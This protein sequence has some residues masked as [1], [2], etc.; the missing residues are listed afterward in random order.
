ML[1][2]EVVPNTIGF[3]RS[4]SLPAG[5]TRV[6][7]VHGGSYARDIQV[8]LHYAKTPWTYGTFATYANLRL[9]CRKASTSTTTSTATSTTVSA[10]SKKVVFN[11]NGG[12][13]VAAKYIKSGKKIGTLPKPTKTGYTF[14]G[15]YTKKSGGSKISAK[16]KV[17]KNV[18]YYA[19]WTAKKYKVTLKKSG[20]GSV[21][22]GGKKAYKS[23]VT[24]KA[25]PAKGYVFDGWYKTVINGEG[26]AESVLVSSKKTWKTKVPLGGATY[27]AVFRKK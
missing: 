21:S 14:K 8:H 22:G 15:W 20:K 5:W 10:N 3:S 19:R 6:G 18:T 26:I 27:T 23:K 17:K 1:Y 11:A 24:L 13:S 25:K 9:T 2:V 4:V 12:T 16:T 7:S